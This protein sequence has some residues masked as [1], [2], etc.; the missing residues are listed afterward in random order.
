MT[1]NI[2]YIILG[3]LGCC[4]FGFLYHYIMTLLLPHSLK[5]D[6]DGYH[7]LLRERNGLATTCFYM[8]R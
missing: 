1:D 5:S 7:L 8:A 6:E 3:S 2:Q 4:T